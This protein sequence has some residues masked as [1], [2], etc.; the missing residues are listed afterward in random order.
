[1]ID[2]NLLKEVRFAEI[3]KGIIAAAYAA[4]W[5]F[6]FGLSDLRTLSIGILL[7]P[8]GIFTS[9]KVKIA[10]DTPQTL[11]ALVLMLAALALLKKL[12]F[13]Q[14]LFFAAFI[15]VLYWSLARPLIPG[16]AE[17]RT[18]A[19]SSLGSTLAVLLLALKLGERSAFIFSLLAFLT[20]S[21]WHI[22][23]AKA[24]QALPLFLA[25]VLLLGYAAMTAFPAKKSASPLAESFA[26]HIREVTDGDSVQVFDLKMSDSEFKS[27][28][29]KE[30][31]QYPHSTLWLVEDEG[32]LLN[33][34]KPVKI[35]YTLVKK[36]VSEDESLV[37][38]LKKRFNATAFDDILLADSFAFL[39]FMSDEELYEYSGEQSIEES[40]LTAII[41]HKKA[42]SG[43]EFAV[44]VPL[45]TGMSAKLEEDLFLETTNLRVNL[46]E[47]WNETDT[48]MVVYFDFIEL[49]GKYRIVYQKKHA[50][51]RNTTTL[52]FQSYP[53]EVLKVLESSEVTEMLVDEETRR[54]GT[55]A[56]LV[57]REFDIAYT[58]EDMVDGY[59]AYVFYG[60]REGHD[61]K[62]ISASW[63]CAAQ[64][65]IFVV[66]ADYLFEEPDISAILGNIRCN[67]A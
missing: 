10:T 67:P 28:I 38:G 61:A 46:G 6:L 31:A 4:A 45:F 18:F 66:T 8:L 60:E 35:N 14:A 26:A 47:G 36:K 24:K 21:G 39:Y 7:I 63:Y 32:I 13:M 42:K 29:N 2:K 5:I 16:I 59:K 62:T 58:A 17:A 64:K 50:F 20:L 53:S 23:R 30:L 11:T 15:S 51:L 65:R 37:S 40:A 52:G 3:P 55:R 33:A 41:R 43:T 49:T 27:I 1:M 48:L 9:E 25:A 19:A 22:F 54:A 56:V 34:K 12:Q 57:E 44:A